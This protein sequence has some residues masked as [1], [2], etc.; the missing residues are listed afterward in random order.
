[1][2]LFDQKYKYL[3]GLTEGSTGTFAT[4]RTDGAD[5]VVRLLSFKRQ[6]VRIPLADITDLRLESI[7]QHVSGGRVL[8][9]GALALAA[10]KTDFALA[11]TYNLAGLSSTL[12]L[13]AEQRALGKLQQEILRARTAAVAH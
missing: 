10:K 9:M 12:M 8:M 1:M 4:A 6:D 5:L 13:Q 3:G 11:V 7:G 2:G